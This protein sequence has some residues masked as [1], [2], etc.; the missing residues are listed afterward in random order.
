[1]VL[2]GRMTGIKGLTSHQQIDP[3]PTK[4]PSF[5]ILTQ[6]LSDILR[7]QAERVANPCCGIRSTGKPTVRCSDTPQWSGARLALKV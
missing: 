2:P 5:L 1:M 4:A 6:T 3:W 7:G